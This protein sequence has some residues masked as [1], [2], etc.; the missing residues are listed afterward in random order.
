VDIALLHACDVNLWQSDALFFA[1][2]PRGE[3]VERHDLHLTS[4]GFPTAEFNR[5]FLKR[6]DGDLPAAIAH[7]EAHFARLALPFFF[8]VRSDWEDRCAPALQAAGYAPLGG[9]PAMLLEPLRDGSARVPGLE[10]RRVRSPGELGPY[11]ETAFEGFGIPKPLA[12]LYLTE[13]ILTAPGV[14]LY[15]GCVDGAPVSTSCLVQTAGVA[16]IYWVATLASHR[17]R[18]L[19]EA[20]TW[21]AVR[22]GM[23]QGCRAA[24][25]QASAMGAPVYGRMGFRTTL[26]YQKYGPAEAR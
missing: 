1:G 14:E 11:R 23:L 7:A 25:L 19:G 26:H 4:C 16:G 24:S 21:A 12:G 5:A 2:S 10:I 17:G 6:P 13:P 9:A 3:V 8:T 15:L 20:L 18:G 22:G